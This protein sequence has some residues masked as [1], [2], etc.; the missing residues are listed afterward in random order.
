M[1][2]FVELNR[3]ELM[4][5]VVGS[6]ASGKSTIILMIQNMLIDKG[7]NVEVTHTDECPM[8]TPEQLDLREKT[9][10]ERNKKISINE[11]RTVK[12][13]IKNETH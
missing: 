9:F 12:N 11:V 6:S 8:M 3:D 2:Q 4:I 13:F 7:L 1:K 5:N 10:I